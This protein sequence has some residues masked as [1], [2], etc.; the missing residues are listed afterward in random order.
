MLNERKIKILKLIINQWMSIDDMAESLG[1]SSRTI[2][3]DLILIIELVEKLGYQVDKDKKH[4]FVH[5]PQLDL[6]M[7]LNIEN[8]TNFTSEEC[9]IF[10]F[11]NLAIGKNQLDL[12]QVANTIYLPVLN[13]KSQTCDFLKR[14]EFEYQL[15]GNELELLITEKQRRELLIALIKQFL[16]T[17]DINQI[18]VAGNLVVVFGSKLQKL[19]EHYFKLAD[20]EA[21]YPEVEDVFN[22]HNIYI[23]DFQLIMCVINICTCKLQSTRHLIDEEHLIAHS[24]ISEQLVKIASISF[25]QEISYL[26]EQLEQFIAELEYEKLD[27][28][29]INQIGLAIRQVEEK[30]GLKFCDPHKLEYQICTHNARSNVYDYQI[31][32]SASLT[33]SSLIN[34]NQAL[35]DQVAKVK[36]LYHT[37]DNLNH[38]FLYFLMAFNETLAKHQWKMQVICFGGMGTSLMIRKQL[39]KEYP[40]ALIENI[41]YARALSRDLSDVDII[42]ANSK[43][44][45]DFEDI[46]VTHVINQGDIKKIN[47]IL[48]SKIKQDR[49]LIAKEQIHYTINFQGDNLEYKT[50]TNELLRFL[51]KQQVIDNPDYVFEKLYKRKQ[52]G[53]G[54]PDSNIA[55]FHTRSSSIKQLTIATYQVTGFANIGFDSKPMDCYWILLVLVPT[56]ISEDLLE[57][58]N[59]LS[60]SLITDLQILEAIMTNDQAYIEQQFD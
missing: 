50:K 38:I 39:E 8:K 33:L 4:Y 17:Q 31:K 57:K 60:Y 47:Q 44:A 43:L 30:I 59:M 12:R 55:F 1:V 6:L 48:L 40:N 15:K 28:L 42:I 2:R 11:K 58:V 29:E 52:I 37:A 24:K 54:I 36:A 20:F 32:Y 16:K 22:E 14:N 27:L 21:I 26:Y 25:P 41:S 10:I 18:I 51:A 5:D 56:D 35:Y 3:R 45:N 19:I 9:L 34:E 49:C 7:N 23:S 46:V 13:L 53:V